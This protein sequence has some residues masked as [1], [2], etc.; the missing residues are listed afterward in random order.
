MSL[1]IEPM[2]EEDY[3][4]YMETAI[5]KYAEAKRTGEG[6]SSEEALEISKKSYENLLPKGLET[7]DHYLHTIKLESS[8]EKIGILW[9]AK[10]TQGPSD[11]AFI[12]DIEITESHQGKG[13][14][15]QSMKLLEAMIRKVGMQ[16]I[17]LHVFG[18]NEKAIKLYES[19]DYK[20]TNIRMIKT[21]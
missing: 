14:G 18:N 10:T 13:Y 4:R 7:D 8:G 21:F 20:P 15:K 6:L 16:G 3:I 11:I 2:S 19:L 5:P 1:L 17:A 12:Y 9:F